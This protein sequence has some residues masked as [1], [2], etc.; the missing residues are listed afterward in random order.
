MISQL[1][2]ISVHVK[3]GSSGDKILGRPKKVV[4]LEKEQEVV[5]QPKEGS[6]WKTP[7]RC[8]WIVKEKSTT[9]FSLGLCTICEASR[10]EKILEKES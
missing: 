5:V 6:D 3:I 1:T 2:Q 9:C 4:V 10:K 7:M 8:N